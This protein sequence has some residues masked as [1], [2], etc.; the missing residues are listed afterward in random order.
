MKAVK[1]TTESGYSWY[2]SVS[3]ASTNKDIEKYFLNQYF[4]IAQYPQEKLEKVVK[5][6]F[7]PDEIKV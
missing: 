2:T 5:V 3:D 7:L 1:L 6:E 4:D